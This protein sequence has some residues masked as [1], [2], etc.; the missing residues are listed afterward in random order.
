MKFES[1]DATVA[2][3]DESPVST[4]AETFVDAVKNAG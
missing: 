4:T 3:I 1:F 2:D